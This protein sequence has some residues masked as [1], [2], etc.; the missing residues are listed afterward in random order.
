[1]L[2]HDCDAFHGRKGSDMRGVSN[3]TDREI[4]A[5]HSSM[6]SVM[7]GSDQGSSAQLCHHSL[8]QCAY[9]SGQPYQP[10]TNQQ[11]RSFMHISSHL[12]RLGKCRHAYVDI[13]FPCF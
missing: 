5:A 7:A 10:T 4:K 12:H 9:I 6:N 8:Q 13:A 2:V 11:Q 1:M 3:A